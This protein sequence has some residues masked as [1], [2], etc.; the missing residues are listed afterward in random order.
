V[1]FQIDARL[2]TA[3]EQVKV[4]FT[5]QIDPRGDWKVTG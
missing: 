3:Q 5:S 2:V 1:R 4:R